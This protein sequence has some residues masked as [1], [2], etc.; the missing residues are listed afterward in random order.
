MQI[1]GGVADTAW[2]TESPTTSVRVLFNA[3]DA[4]TWF[5]TCGGGGWIRSISWSMIW[6]VASV[7]TA[8]CAGRP[9][10]KAESAEV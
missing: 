9:Y 3:T 8:N 10:S 7:A 2:Q 5:N 4:T 1:T 6:P